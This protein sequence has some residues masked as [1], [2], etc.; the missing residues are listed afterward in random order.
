[1]SPI[2]PAASAA[3]RQNAATARA[4]RARRHAA[5]ST[6]GA[7]TIVTVDPMTRAATAAFYPVF[8]VQPQPATYPCARTRMPVGGMN[9]S[10][11]R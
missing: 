4:A 5:A 7:A 1:M 2:S 11:G 3:R 8:R 9:I 6:A 10:A